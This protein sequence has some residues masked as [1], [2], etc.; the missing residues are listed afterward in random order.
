MSDNKLTF[1]DIC[2]HAEDAYRTLFNRKEWPP[3]RH[4]RDSKAPPASFNLADAMPMTRSEVMLL[5]QSKSVSAGGNNKGTSSAKTGNCHKCGKPGHWSRECPNGDVTNGNDIRGGSGG[6][7][8]RSGNGGRLSSDRASRAPTSNRNR[9][10]PSVGNPPFWKTV[11]PQSGAPITKQHNNRTF[12]WCLKS[13]RWTMTHVT[14]THTGGKAATNNTVPDNRPSVNFSLIQDPS[15]WSTAAG[16]YPSMPDVW[17]GFCAAI[18]ALFP[19]SWL[20]LWVLACVSAPHL[21]DFMQVVGSVFRASAAVAASTFVLL[22]A[23]DWD[24]IALQVSD[25][26]MQLLGLSWLTIKSCWPYSSDSSC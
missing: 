26:A 10:A 9:S 17:F 14:A 12:N 11:A 24:S 16:G 21:L 23:M 5:M 3:A 19:V 18:D 1:K 15:V 7:P 13:K 6:R 2:T 4:V 25:A 22:Q 8:A 20:F